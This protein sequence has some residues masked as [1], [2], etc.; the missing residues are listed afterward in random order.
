MRGGRCGAARLDPSFPL[1]VPL[2][3]A[4]PDQLR[5]LAAALERGGVEGVSDPA[6]VASALRRYLQEAPNGL[7]LDEA[8]GLVPAPGHPAWWTTEARQRRDDVIRELA[9][10]HYAGLSVRETARQIA[11]LGRECQARGRRPQS[12][13]DDRRR[14]A[15]AA[16]ETGAPFPGPRQVENVLRAK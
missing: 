14:L 1:T 12:A 15:V 8:L 16:I 7:T 4:P 10:R 6:K 11:R 5:A 2:A 9:R 13:G 3:G